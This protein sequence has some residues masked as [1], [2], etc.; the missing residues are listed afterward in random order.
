[1]AGGD[2]EMVK[3]ETMTAGAIK[4]SNVRKEFID[5]KGETIIALDN[6]NVDISPGEFICLIG[7]PAVENLLF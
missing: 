7:P 3:E 2:C 4:V 5:T 6:V 1:M